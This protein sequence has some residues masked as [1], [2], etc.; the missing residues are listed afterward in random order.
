[1]ADILS[2][3]MLKLLHRLFLRKTN[4]LKKKKQSPPQVAV[5]CAA[6]ENT[7]FAYDQQF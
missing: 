4:S 2:V 3:T 5:R 1:M 7:L 6:L